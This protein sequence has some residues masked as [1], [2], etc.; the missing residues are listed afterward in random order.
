MSAENGH[1]LGRRGEG[2]REAGAPEGEEEPAEKHRHAFHGD[3]DSGDRQL[4]HCAPTN[5]TCNKHH[6]DTAHSPGFVFFF[7]NKV[8]NY[9]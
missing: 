6:T 3:R 2:A 9:F 7:L 8:A 4:T 5:S 1:S